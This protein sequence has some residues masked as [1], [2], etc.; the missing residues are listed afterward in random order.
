[1]ERRRLDFIE[2]RSNIE[3]KSEFFSA[4]NDN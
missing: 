1:L 4:R 2:R 3:R